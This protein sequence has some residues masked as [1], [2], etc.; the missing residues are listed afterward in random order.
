MP[1]PRLDQ[2]TNP[3]PSDPRPT[4]LHADAERIRRVAAGD[5]TADAE[6]YTEHRPVALRVAARHCRPADVDDVVADAFL[7]VLDQI[8]RGGGPQTSFRA[9]LLTAV[10]HAATDLARADA[11]ISHHEITD[12]LPARGAPTEPRED[13]GSDRQV[14]ARVL[15]DALA[16]LPGRWQLA[17]WWSDVEGRPMDEIGARL[18]LNANA[19]AAL[20]FRAREGLRQAYLAQY[21]DRADDPRCRPW[22]AQLPALLRRKLSDR[23]ASRLAEHLSVC[24]PCADAAERLQAVLAQ[25]V[26]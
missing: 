11:R 2:R 23:A 22:R 5:A 1:S 24:R 25:P 6:L 20:T 18:G 10:R 19:A 12:D 16:T 8:R 17:V 3:A 21:V 9:Y 13:A 14:D 15:G 4:A 7:R 26:G